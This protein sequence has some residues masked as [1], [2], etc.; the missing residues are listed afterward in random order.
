MAR[1]LQVLPQHSGRQYP[2]DKWTNGRPWRASHGED[3]ECD[4]GVFRRMLTNHALRH[5]MKVVTRVVGE[6][7]LFQFSKA[8]AA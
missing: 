1:Q 2:W 6:D 5:G 4:P 7:V 3:F 8:A